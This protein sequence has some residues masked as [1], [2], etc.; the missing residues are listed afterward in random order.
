VEVT[1]ILAALLFAS[2]QPLTV[3]AMRDILQR[4]PDTA[5]LSDEAIHAAL[6]QLNE[7]CQDVAYPFEVQPIAGGYQ[8]LSKAIYHP[9]VRHTAAVSSTKKLSR[10]ALETLAVVAYRQPITKGEI[11]FVRGVNCDYAMQKLLDRNLISIAGRSDAPGRPLLY[12]SS[13]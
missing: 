10:A 11:E 4:E 3:A 7:R 9:Y 5:A 13:P 8:L 1:N 2:D 12:V 6:L